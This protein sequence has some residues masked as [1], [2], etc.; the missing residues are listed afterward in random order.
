MK[1]T[2]EV[3]QVQFTDMSEVIQFVPKEQNSK[4][5]TEEIRDVSVSSSME[6]TDEFLKIVPQTSQSDFEEHFLQE[7]VDTSIRQVME[8]IVELV[9]HT[10]QE[11]VF[12]AN[13]GTSR[14]STK[15]HQ[16]SAGRLRPFTI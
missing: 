3:P 11:T 10:R 6:E 14:I 8:D 5:K 16:H 7:S 4:C 15:I 9:K 12:D 2:V 1:K 13:S